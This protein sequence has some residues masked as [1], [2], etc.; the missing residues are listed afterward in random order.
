MVSKLAFESLWKKQNIGG[1]AINTRTK[2]TKD[3]NQNYTIPAPHILHEQDD[4]AL[5]TQPPQFNVNA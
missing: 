3:K 1:D 5:S 2:T 4:F